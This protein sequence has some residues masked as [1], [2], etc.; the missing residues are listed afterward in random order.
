MERMRTLKQILISKQ[1]L[2]K[3]AVLPR[4]IIYSF[5]KVDAGLEEET[6]YLDTYVF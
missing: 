4:R 5:K 1:L 3:P 6:V 2:G